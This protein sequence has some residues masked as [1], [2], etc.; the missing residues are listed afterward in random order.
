MVPCE[1][2]Q[3]GSMSFRKMN[4]FFY[5]LLYAIFLFFSLWYKPSLIYSQFQP[6]FYFDQHFLRSFLEYPGGLSDALSTFIF[7]FFFNDIIGSF[8]FATI[9]ASI[10]LFSQAILKRQFSITLPSLMVLTPLFFLIMLYN[11]YNIPLV[12]ALKFAIVL[13]GAYLYGKGKTI[14]RLS[15]LCAFP[16]IYWLLGGWFSLYFVFIILFI[17]IYY[18]WSTLIFPVLFGLIYG[19]SAYLSARFLFQISLKEAFLYV[20]PAQ[21]YLPPFLFEHGPLFYLLFLSIPVMLVTQRASQVFY[22]KQKSENVLMKKRAVRIIDMATG[23][24][25][26]CAGM[27]FSVQPDQKRKIYINFLAER[28][29]WDDVLTESRRMGTYDRI[30]EFQSNRAMYFTGCLLDSLFEIEHPM[31]V[32][33]LFVDRMMASQIALYASD[34]Y[35]DL[36]YINAAQVMAYE[37]LTKFRYD[38]RPLK[39]LALTNALNGYPLKTEKFLKLL[40]KSIVHRRWAEQHKIL[41]DENRALEIP[42]VAEKKRLMPT[43]DF[44]LS[45][46][47]PNTDMVALLESN[48]GNRMA[49]E[50]LV[51][52]HLLECRLGNIAKYIGMLKKF[53]YQSVPRHVEEAAIMYQTGVA[54]IG[55]EFIKD[56]PFRRDRISMFARFNKILSDN[57]TNMKRADQLLRTE[58]G[59]TFWYYLYSGGSDRTDIL[60]KRKIESEF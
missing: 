25:L 42:G 15:F 37:Y 57:R 7:Q 56:I 49:F 20:M 16:G 5:F 12:I 31:G 51:A 23:I 58:F 44:F 52:Y 35:Y 8:L 6:A 36:G 21:Y 13:A 18:R 9:L 14:T 29:E 26:L 41:L 11:E 54:Q 22:K 47:N 24:A 45:S 30:V 17:H 27:I 48:D 50:Y 43:G 19:L 4:L 53:G 39:R 33:G 40:G 59:D 32:N 55:G 1:S 38:P 34:L 60:K 28:E 46:K 3:G 2:A 10:F